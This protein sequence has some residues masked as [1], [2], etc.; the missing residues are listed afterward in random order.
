MATR[1]HIRNNQDISSDGTKTDLVLWSLCFTAMSIYCSFVLGCKKK[2]IIRSVSVSHPGGFCGSCPVTPAWASFQPWC[3]RAVARG[4]SGV[5]QGG[6]SVC[7]RR[8]VTTTTGSEHLTAESPWRFFLCSFCLLIAWSNFT[9][10][11]ITLSTIRPRDDG[12]AHVI[13]FPII[14][15][16][17]FGRCCV[18]QQNNWQQNTDCTV[19]T[20]ITFG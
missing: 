7:G 18:C 13:V 19:F 5:G 3:P 11:L 12:H 20:M 8:P 2:K 17:S 6:V 10:L 4:G 9:I 16:Q 15:S 1:G 14:H